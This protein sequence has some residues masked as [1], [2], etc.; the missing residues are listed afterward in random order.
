M[1][2]PVISEVYRDKSTLLEMREMCAYD[3]LT[4]RIEW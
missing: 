1:K 2:D 3:T 4:Q